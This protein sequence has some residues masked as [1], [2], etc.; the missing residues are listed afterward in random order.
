LAP[1][2]AS[3]AV[4]ERVGPAGNGHWP[5]PTIT[6]GARLPSGRAVLGGLLVT[7]AVIGTFLAATAGEQGPSEEY[8]VAARAIDQGERLEPGDVRT[9][10]VDLPP[11]VARHAF[12]DP[13]AL[14]GAVALAPLREGSLVEASQV[15]VAA[16]AGEPDAPSHE[17]S[18]RLPR[19]Q[20]LDGALNRGEWVDVLATYGSSPDATTLVV[21][22]HALV[23]SLGASSDQSL[24]DDGGLTLTLQLSDA[25]AV[26]RLTHAKD[27]ATV[28]L[29]RATR[30]AGGDG[31]PERYDGPEVPPV[32]ASP[33]EDASP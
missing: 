2:M 24:G 23:T 28:T 14:D 4:G 18:L 6:R 22:H 31:S 7:L 5:T 1:V 20:A 27:V 11:S 13:A 9:L 15:L 26:L 25:D 21:A 8:L 19:A 29:V 16:G 3:D 12:G 33:S 30:D 17:V 32:A 10:A